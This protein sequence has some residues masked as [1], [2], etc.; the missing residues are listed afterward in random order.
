LPTSSTGLSS[1]GDIP[2]LWSLAVRLNSGGFK[3]LPSDSPVLKPDNSS[4]DSR[5]ALE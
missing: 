3:K 5:L 1:Y 4:R 2:V